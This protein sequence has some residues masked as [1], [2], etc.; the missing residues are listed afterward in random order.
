L[1]QIFPFLIAVD[2]SFWIDWIDHVEISNRWLIWTSLLQN[3]LTLQDTL[4]LY[5]IIDFVQTFLFEC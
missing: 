2:A 4:T 5:S 1:L 3:T